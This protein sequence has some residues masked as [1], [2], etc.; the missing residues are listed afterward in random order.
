MNTHKD[1]SSNKD[2]DGSDPGVRALVALFI[3]I[4]TAVGSGP[5][6]VHH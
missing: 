2:K 3:A 6:G 1:D 4:S 5:W